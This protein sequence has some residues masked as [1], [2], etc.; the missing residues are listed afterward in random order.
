MFNESYT[1][2]S[3]TQKVIER[4]ALTEISK[5]IPPAGLSSRYLNSNRCYGTAYSS[6]SQSNVLKSAESL[7]SLQAHNPYG[8]STFP[9]TSAVVPPAPAATIVQPNNELLQFI[10]KQEG[11]I[12]QLERESQFC[13]VSIPSRIAITTMI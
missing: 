3:I 11:Y 8:T 9:T 13:R 6:G 1:I 12:E 2:V 5:Y 10:E 7:T 4:P